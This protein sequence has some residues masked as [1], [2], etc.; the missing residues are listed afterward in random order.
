MKINEIQLGEVVNKLTSCVIKGEA[1]VRD[2]YSTCLK[3]LITESE[4]A[5]GKIICGTLMAPLMK[6]KKEN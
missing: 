2:I 3:T 6:G 1:N 5:R 4:E